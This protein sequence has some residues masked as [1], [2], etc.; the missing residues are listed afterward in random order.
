M[1]DNK[2]KN[3]LCLIKVKGGNVSVIHWKVLA[4]EQ[5]IGEKGDRGSYE[6]FSLLG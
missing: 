6:N 4:D 2:F 3:E 1:N 5:R